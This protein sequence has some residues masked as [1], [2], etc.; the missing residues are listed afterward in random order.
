MLLRPVWMGSAILHSCPRIAGKGGECCLSNIETP[1]WLE[2]YEVRGVQARILIWLIIN[3][4]N[5]LRGWFPSNYVEVI[6]D[7]PEMIA[8][9]F[10]LNQSSTASKVRNFVSLFFLHTH[11]HPTLLNQDKKN[12]KSIFHPPYDSHTTT[13]KLMR[14][15]GSM[16]T[17]LIIT[18]NLH[19]TNSNSMNWRPEVKNN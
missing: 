14:T 8:G 19:S 18:M 7:E 11:T 17:I 5:G 9:D 10:G 4:C 6:E 16:R 1:W 12:S 3:R 2:C 15:S 13:S